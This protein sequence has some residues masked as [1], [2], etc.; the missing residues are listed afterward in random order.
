MPPTM[1]LPTEMAMF[2]KKIIR[3]VLISETIR[4]EAGTNH[5]HQI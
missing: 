4:A 5:K 1:F 2:F 3:G